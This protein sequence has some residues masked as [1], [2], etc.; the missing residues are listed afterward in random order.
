MEVELKKL[1][2]EIKNMI[3]QRISKIKQDEQ[4]MNELYT[5][6]PIPITKKKMW[7]VWYHANIQKKDFVKIVS[8]P[9]WE[10]VK[11]LNYPILDPKIYNDI[12]QYIENLWRQ[13]EKTPNSYNWLTEEHL[14]DI[15][16]VSLNWIFENSA[17]WE[18]FAKKWKTDIYLVIDKGNILKFECKYRKWVSIVEPTINQL[19]DYTTWRDNYWSIILFIKAKWR[20][21]ILQKIEEQLQLYPTIIWNVKKINES[22]FQCTIRN[23]DDSKK[24]LHLTCLCFFIGWE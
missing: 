9:K 18:T 10:W 23:P 12:L 19:L 16:L 17:T 21:A 2:I 3:N 5:A 13:F 8:K 6:S 22:H 4:L 20:T 15:I 1:A 24:T 14:R 7:E 11:D